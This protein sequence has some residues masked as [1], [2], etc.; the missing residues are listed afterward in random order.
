M[1]KAKGK[2]FANLCMKLFWIFLIGSVFGYVAEML[3]SLVYTRTLV[4]RQGLL[5]GP[6]VQ[7][8]GF[9]AIAY[10]L[11]VSKI[12]EPKQVFFA[13]MLMGG[14]LEYLC[15]F[16]QEIFFGTISWDYSNLFLN[17]NGR[18]CLLYCLYWGIIGVVFLKVFFP[19]FEKIDIIWERK[20]GKW[21]TGILFIF[22]LFDVIISCMAATRQDERRKH[23]SPKNAVDIFL[24]E[25][26]P[27]EFMDRIYNNK[28]NIR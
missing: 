8:Y 2:T 20:K 12:R 25:T 16:F 7:V 4:F 22:L 23:I 18:T 14:V 5:Y 3:Y 15:S 11:L 17:I 9:G 21:L 28:I 26:Y 10:Y 1:E 13:G 27:D 19:L 24:D 6:F